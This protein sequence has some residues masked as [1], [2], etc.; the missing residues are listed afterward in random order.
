M[1]DWAVKRKLIS[2]ENMLIGLAVMFA[3]SAFV[4]TIVTLTW[5]HIRRLVV[6]AVPQKRESES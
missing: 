1:L 4:G 3:Y 5:Y 2:S 6:T